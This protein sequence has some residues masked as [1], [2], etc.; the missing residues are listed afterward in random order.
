LKGIPEARADD[1]DMYENLSNDL[2]TRAILVKGAGGGLWL[3][4]T[5]KEGAQR[6]K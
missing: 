3:A 1:G 6:L 2:W 5:T 4:E